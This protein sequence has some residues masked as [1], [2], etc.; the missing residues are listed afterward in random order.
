MIRHRVAN[1]TPRIVRAL[2]ELQY[3][4]EEGSQLAR[5]SPPE[6]GSTPGLLSANV[7]DE[8]VRRSAVDQTGR[9]DAKA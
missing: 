9:V 1:G 8:E 7:M 3:A 2:A 5:W 4:G 6:G